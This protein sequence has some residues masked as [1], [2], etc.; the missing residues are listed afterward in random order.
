MKKIQIYVACLFVLSMLVVPCSAFAFFGVDIGAGYWQQ[1]P[2]GNF[3]YQALSPSDQLDLQ[4]DL[5][6]DKQ[7]KPFFRAKV[8][9]PLIL[10]NIYFMATPMK[11]DGSGPIS[12]TINFGGESFPANVSIDSTLKLDH[13]DLALYYPLPFLKTATAG[14]LSV[15]LGLDARMF[16]FEGSLSEPASNLTASDKQTFYIPMLYAAII[17]KPI[18]LLSIELEARASSYGSNHYYDYIGRLRINPIPLIFIGG[19]YRAE[20]V[21]VDESDVLADIKFKGPFVEAG[22]SF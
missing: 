8:E 11:F 2:S 22:F 6:Y 17:V 15:E 5:Y 21:K 7:N 13:Y 20:E 18:D 12:R 1:N 10:P 3:S 19:G 9:L 14:I 16:D 4:N